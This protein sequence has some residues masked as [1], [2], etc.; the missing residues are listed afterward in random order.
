VRVVRELRTWRFRRPRLRLPRWRWRRRVAA[1]S[2]DDTV[3]E[4][5]ALEPDGDRSAAQDAVRAALVPLREPTDPR[6]AVIEAYAR[7]EAVLGERQLS[8]RSPEAPREYLNRVLRERGMPED[9][10]VTLTALFEEARFSR[11]P[12][13]ESAPRR[14]ASE[15]EA[16]RL[17]LA[18]DTGDAHT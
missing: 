17:A 7:M 11:H 6:A 3:L 8:R 14:A 10:L 2:G 15:L 5:A 9:S 1:Q 18:R 4:P 13:P 16:A 12:I